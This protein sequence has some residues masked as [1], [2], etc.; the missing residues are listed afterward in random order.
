[1]SSADRKSIRLVHDKKALFEL[2]SEPYIASIL[3]EG[4]FPKDKKVPFVMKSIQSQICF[5]Q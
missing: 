3:K 1:M 2:I 4:Y 5:F